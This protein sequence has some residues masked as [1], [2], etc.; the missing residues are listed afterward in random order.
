[1]LWFVG[2]ELLPV[3]H[4]AFHGAFGEHRHGVSHDH[5]AAEDH[6]HDHGDADHGAE[7]E[8][9][10]SDR[11][12]APSEHGKGSL[13]HRDLAAEVPVPTIPIVPEALLARAVTFERRPDSL[14]SARRPDTKRARAPPPRPLSHGILS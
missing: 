11:H 10:P 4:L 6:A 7:V 9:N 3:V 14:P 12:E 5:H 13:A 8:H 2:F 1:V